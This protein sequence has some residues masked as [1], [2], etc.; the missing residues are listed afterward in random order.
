MA[1]TNS[2]HV[3]LGF[4]TNWSHGKIQGAT[5]TLTRQNGG[6]LIAFLAIFIGMV[7]KSFWRL[8]C[9][10]LHRYFSSA[11]AQDGLHHQ[12]QAILRNSD[13]AQDGAWRML[14]SMMAWRKGR[15]A[16]RP[17]LRLLPIIAAAFTI[18]AAF[19]V[20]S[21]FS[22]NV[23][24]ETL[25]QV[26]LK[27]TRCGSYSN[28]KANSVY[29]Q[30]TLLLPL[31][32][33]KATKFLNYGMQCY[34]NETHTDGC[35]LYIKPRLPLVSTRGVPCP[36]GDNICKLD[37]DNLVM[38]TGLLDSLDDLGINTAP[39][40]RFQFRMVYTCAPLKTQGYMRDYNDSDYGAVKR[41]MYGE[42]ENVR[43]VINHTYEVPVDNAYLPGDGTSS[44]NI[45]R[46]E[47]QLGIEKHYGTPNETLLPG[48]NEWSPLDALKLVDADVHL[49]FMSAPEIHY[50]GPIDDP[51]FSA[52][53]NASELNDQ[54][55]KATFSAWLQD[56][57][58]GVMACTQQVQYCNPNLPEGERCEPLR[59]VIDPRKSDRVKKI[60]PTDDGFATIKWVDNL[61][62]YGV[63]TISATV[64]FIGASALRAR[65]G[66]S[67]GYS[68]A[69]PNNQWQLEAEHWIKGT[70]A[71]LQD[72]FVEAAN[73]IPEALEDFRQPPLANETM[74]QTMCANQKIVS[75]N[76]SSFNV[77]GLSLILILGVLII[78]FDISLEPA[79]ASWQRRQYRRR[80]LK[81][82]TY[83]DEKTAHPLYGAIEWSQTN[84]LQLQRLAQEEAG[85]GEWTGCDGDV[86]VTEPGQ[87]LAGL[88]LRKIVH[89]Q[90][91][92]KM[93][94]ETPNSEW[95]ENILPMKPWGLR[96]S[97]T[98]MDTLVEEMEAVKEGKDIEEEMEVVVHV[99][100]DRDEDQ[101][102]GLG[103]RLHEDFEIR[104][105]RNADWRVLR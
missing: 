77:L 26:L 70:L 57:P 105:E 104:Q 25:N 20:A 91:R 81:D 19:G 17:I 62:T 95:E 67:Y 1:S 82:E 48:V 32:A 63:Y 61:W 80:Q 90:L 16:R 69:L 72:V 22:S 9:F 51:W 78:L 86:P 65:Y 10:A 93:Q 54:N 45:P 6:F 89:P 11:A 47:Y 43:Q 14:M 84:I 2:Y 55:T 58:V 59:G 68:A 74:A 79:V 40:N 101:A 71:S 99:V 7:G 60:F 83:G 18:S 39:A 92:L 103:V 100:A 49:L 23:T 44:A 27:G 64:G 28:K 66:L 13:T 98:G 56:E 96:R 52:H 85:Y 8:G 94:E 21:I 46:L 30:L 29:K 35:N 15:R 73:G 5:V 12:R 38:D 53:K 75:T 102:R 4:W 36:F 42:V 31:Q 41:Y 33:E 37:N 88:D 34:T 24:S 97:D 50:A 76:Y 87:L 3:H